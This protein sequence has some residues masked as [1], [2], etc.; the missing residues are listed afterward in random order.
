LTIVRERPDAMLLPAHG[1]VTSSVH[2]R[3]DELV[4]HHRLRLDAMQAALEWG[5]DTAAM[6][7]AK[8]TWTKRERKLEDLDVFNQF[9]AVCET[10]AHLE[11]LVAQGRAG[12]EIRDGVRCYSAV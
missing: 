8:V 11:L 4:E 5:C 3:V 12:K 9:L 1:P 6:V 10:G 2:D 7:A